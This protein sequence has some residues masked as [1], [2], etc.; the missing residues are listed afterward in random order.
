VDI[1]IS[2][3]QGWRSRIGRP[4]T[5]RRDAIATVGRVTSGLKTGAAS[6]RRAVALP[7]RV[8]G[9]SAPNGRQLR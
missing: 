9:R 8:A 4:A 6:L 1:P 7:R 2:S 3:L 5:L